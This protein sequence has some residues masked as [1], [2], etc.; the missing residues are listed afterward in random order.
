VEQRDPEHIVRAYLEQVTRELQDIPVA[1]QQEILSDLRAHIDEAVGGIEKA[2]EAEVRTVLDR[3]G[4]P[5]DVAREAKEQLPAT[6]TETKSMPES[7][8][9]DKTPSALEVAAII[10]TALFWPIGVLLAW[11]SPRWLT[12]D[13]VIATLIPAATSALLVLVVLGGLVV[14]GAESSVVSVSSVVDEQPAG[15]SGSA[16]PEPRSPADLGR[17][18]ASE[19]AGARVLVVFTFIGAVVAGPFVTA[20]FLAIR[21]RPRVSATGVDSGRNR[22]QL[23]GTQSFSSGMSRR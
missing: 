8:E 21:L 7:S 12:R 10:L 3:L 16:H 23:A 2:S 15:P 22:D 19:G 5:H 11:I 1:E 14:Y 4:H 18:A 20:V 9:P 6:E 17:E 13:K